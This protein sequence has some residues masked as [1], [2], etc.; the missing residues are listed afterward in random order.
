MELRREWGAP[1]AGAGLAA[2]LDS[3]VFEPYLLVAGPLMETGG[4]VEA[5]HADQLRSGKGLFFF[6]DGASGAG[7]VSRKVAPSS[8]PPPRHHLV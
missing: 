4:S 1:M 2:S 8:G 7:G 6:W 3:L 5:E